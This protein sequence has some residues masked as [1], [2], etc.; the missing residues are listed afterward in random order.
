[1]NDGTEMMD[2]DDLFTEGNDDDHDD[3]DAGVAANDSGDEEASF[4]GGF[5][6]I[7]GG[8]VE[9]G[10]LTDTKLWENVHKGKIC[11]A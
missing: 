1:M 2:N 11:G 5:L 7:I 9:A 4:S 10:A 6:H 3:A 8:V